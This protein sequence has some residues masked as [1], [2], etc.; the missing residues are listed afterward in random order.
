MKNSVFASDRQH[1]IDRTAAQ[2][3]IANL[4]SIAQPP[5]NS[6]VFFDGASL[7][8][9]LSGAEVTG[10]HYYYARGE[11]IGDELIVVPSTTRNEHP[12]VPVGIL[13]S[14]AEMPRDG[15]GN[16]APYAV[17]HGISWLEAGRKTRVYRALRDPQQPKGG[18]F[19]ADALR[20]LL[21]QAPCVGAQFLFGADPEGVRNIVIAG[22]DARG[23]LMMHG[24][25]IEL[26]LLCPPFCFQDNLLNSDRFLEKTALSYYQ[27]PVPAELGPLAA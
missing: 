7:L 26:S 2:G 15:Q 4:S 18:F 14:M 17:D 27:S 13:R 11:G 22:V 6:G 1:K 3:F 16:Y 5:L 23:N 20:R 12:L 25:L 21:N 8:K 9:L 19:G 10:L 24:E